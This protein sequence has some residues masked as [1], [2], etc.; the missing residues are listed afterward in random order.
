[1]EPQIAVRCELL[2][3]LPSSATG[4]IRSITVRCCLL[5]GDPSKVEKNYWLLLLCTRI[6][7]GPAPRLSPC[8]S[9]LSATSQQYFYLRTNQPPATSQ[10]YFSLR[11]NQHQ[12]SAISHQPNEQVVCSSSEN[13]F[14]GVLLRPHKE[15][16]RGFIS[17]LLN[18]H[19]V[20]HKAAG[21]Y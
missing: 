1:V 2:L 15:A 19:K 17:S 5:H 6:E 9:D 18:V 13:Q 21:Y 3:L 4:S 8:S 10:Q 7:G 20:V 14:R 16:T 12:P 11:T